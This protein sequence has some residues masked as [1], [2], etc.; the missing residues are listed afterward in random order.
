[1]AL[2]SDAFS[3]KLTGAAELDAAFKILGRKVRD[4]V[5]PMALRASTKPII[6]IAK[7]RAG[8]IS[9]D[10]Q[11]SIGSKLPRRKSDYTRIIVI[12]P[13]KM[14]GMVDSRGRRKDPSKIGHLIEDDTKPHI[15]KASHGKVFQRLLSSGNKE[16]LARLAAKGV[17]A[18]F[19]PLGPM[20]GFA[21]E[22]AQSVNHPGTK[23]RPFMRPAWDGGKDKATEAYMQ[24]AREAINKIVAGLPKGKVA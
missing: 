16:S 5:V 2:E 4:R 7:E 9:K 19:G 11:K 3:M 14:K 20:D 15:I 8:R 22:F 6:G 17:T 21:I 23:G 12:G 18:T 1:M 10:L 13:R 24:R